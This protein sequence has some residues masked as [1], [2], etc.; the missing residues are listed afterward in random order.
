MTQLAGFVIGISLTNPNQIYFREVPPAQLARMRS[1][2]AIEY[3]KYFSRA[4]TGPAVIV[5]TLDPRAPARRP[6]WPALAPSSP[7]FYVK[8]RL[9]D[10]LKNYLRPWAQAR[11]HNQMHMAGVPT[12]DILSAPSAPFVSPA[13]QLAWS[14]L[15][16]KAFLD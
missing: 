11:G 3:V 4:L 5:T 2:Q 8:G 6:N 12:S 7:F 15:E 14:F 16:S 1:R 13:A 10:C 9:I